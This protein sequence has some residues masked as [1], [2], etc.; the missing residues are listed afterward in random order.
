MNNVVDNKRG[1]SRYDSPLISVIMPIYN[2]HRYLNDSIS[3]IFAQTIDNWELICIDDGSIDGSFEIC[4]SLASLDSRIIPLRQKHTG[5]SA[6]RNKGISLSCGDYIYLL[7]GDDYIEPQTLERCVD[8]ALT[9]DADIVQFEARLLVQDGASHN[10]NQYIRSLPY[11]GVWTGP[12][13]YVAQRKAGDYFAQACMYLSRASVFKGMGV[14]FPMGVIHED[15]YG[16]YAALMRSKKVV[17]L[18]E[19]LYVRRYRPGSIMSSRD[20]QAST[21][22]YFRVYADVLSHDFGAADNAVVAEARELCLDEQ[23]VRIITCFYRTGA[24]LDDF[25]QVAG[26]RRGVEGDEE[27]L[28]RLLACDGLNPR[29]FVFMRAVT[30]LRVKLSPLK[31]W[32]KVLLHETV[33]LMKNRA[34]TL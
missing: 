2:I 22:G 34:G 1:N 14:P 28:T 7:D 29:W 6:A 11:P 30:R 5:L 3:S 21:R 27:A 32:V 15:E 24:P 4:K 17:C 8:A 18:R 33:D 16:T 25:A 9:Y 20:W 31:Q 26:V 13:L 12:E 23:L 10:L 19:Q